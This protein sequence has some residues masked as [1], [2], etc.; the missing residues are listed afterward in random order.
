LSVDSGAPD[1]GRTDSQTRAG[2]QAGRGLAGGVA[3]FRTLPPPPF[4][5]WPPAAVP[6]GVVQVLATLV[7]SRLYV[8]RLESW[9]W[10]KGE[11]GAE[12]CVDRV[13]LH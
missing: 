2:P 11:G 8:W 13:H 1:S 7:H 3:I 10:D 6:H 4:V 5:M 9:K 12:R